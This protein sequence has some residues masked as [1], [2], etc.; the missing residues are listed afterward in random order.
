MG[1]FLFILIS[2]IQLAGGPQCLETRDVFDLLVKVSISTPESLASAYDDLDFIYIENTFLMLLMDGGSRTRNL[3]IAG[4]LVGVHVLR[5]HPRPAESEAPGGP[6][7]TL[8]EAQGGEH[9]L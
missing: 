7:L 4:E 9:L 1:L 8:M 2:L 5:P 6:P 3:S